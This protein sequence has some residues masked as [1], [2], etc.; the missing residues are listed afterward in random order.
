MNNQNEAKRSCPACGGSD[1]V[2]ESR[3]QTVEYRGL[4]SPPYPQPG[5]WCRACGEGL[6]SFKEM[7][8]GTREM[9][10]LKARVENLLEP[11][12]VK[13][14]RK[15]LGLTQKEAGLL[16]GG[17]PSAF[18]KYESADIVTSQAISNLLRVLDHNPSALE[19]LR[20]EMSRRAAQSAPTASMQG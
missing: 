12:E 20:R 11:G 13:R 5:L 10:K 6:L 16:L 2:Q 8:V 4:V 17:G 9:H 7:E 14:V 3:T 15:K 1:L 18:Q 19:V